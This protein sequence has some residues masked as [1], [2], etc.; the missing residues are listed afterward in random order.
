MAGIE[1]GGLEC[2]QAEKGLQSAQGNRPFAGVDCFANIPRSLG[3][4]RETGLYQI[5]SGSMQE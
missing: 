5:S 4:D 3:K 1:D 2:L